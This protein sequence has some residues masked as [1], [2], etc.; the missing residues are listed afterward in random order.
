M[1]VQFQRLGPRLHVLEAAEGEPSPANGGRVSALVA[2]EDGARL[3]LVGAG[4]TPAVGLA[5]GTALRRPVTDL[6][7]TRAHGPLTLGAA[8]FPRARRWA[9]A[10]TA[11]AMARDCASCRAALAQ[12]IGPLAATT[13]VPDQVRL[14]D[15]RIDP[16]GTSRG[17]L[18][19]FE[20]RVLRRSEG[21]PALVLR[22]GG[23]RWWL[24]QGLAWPGALPDLR[25]TDPAVLAASWARLHDALE[26]GDRLIGERGAAG[27]RVNLARHARYL[28][29][30]QHWADDAL[31]A[32]R[33]ADEALQAWPGA[34]PPDN[35]A[36]Q[37]ALN[38]QR[39]WRAREDAW[40]T[41]GAARPP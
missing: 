14:P 11:A 38:A 36:A 12:A 5:V 29:Q 30:L 31:A 22:V 16:R 18:G 35:Q 24:A 23:T 6:V 21:Q 28:Q 3:W 7:F 13:L 20:W 15:H 17:R 8:A 27:S 40:L 34:A 1:S 37:H 32:G 33:S 25:G 26:P 19:P 9:L 39:V 41:P 10:A 2:V 4:P